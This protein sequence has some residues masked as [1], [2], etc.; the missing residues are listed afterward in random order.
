MLGRLRRLTATLYIFAQSSIQLAMGE[1]IQANAGS[2]DQR[3][4]IMLYQ[5][6]ELKLPVQHNMFSN[7][8]EDTF[9]HQVI[10]A[11]VSSQFPARSTTYSVD[12]ANGEARG[13]RKRRGHGYR[14]DAC[15]KKHGRQIAF[16]EV[17]PPGDSHTAKEYLW[18]YWNLA[19]YT[20]DAIDMS[21]QE[22]Y[23]IVKAAAVQL[24]SK[25]T[26]RTN[27]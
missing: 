22:G 3:K 10:D 7:G 21:L 15:I 6:L 16:L 24:F 9:C 20:K 12:W 17:K 27:V 2:S 4:I 1:Q 19:N 11:L 14:P 8:L 13:S 26:K 5:M 25:R 18:D 23:P